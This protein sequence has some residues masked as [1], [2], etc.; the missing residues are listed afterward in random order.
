M[1]CHNEIAILGKYLR[2]RGFYLQS[3]MNMMEMRM[4]MLAGPY[5]SGAAQEDDQSLNASEEQERTR[6]DSLMLSE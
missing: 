4:K 5:A 6:K 1:H 3:S 2:S